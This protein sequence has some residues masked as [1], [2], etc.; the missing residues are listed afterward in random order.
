MLGSVLIQWA[1]TI[2]TQTRFGLITG[3]DHSLTVG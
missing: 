3:E 1:G 2:Y